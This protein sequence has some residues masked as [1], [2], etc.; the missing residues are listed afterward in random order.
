MKEKRILNILGQVNEDYIEEAAPKQK[1]KERP[2]WIRTGAM[3]ACLCLVLIGVL[4]FNQSSPQSFGLT[5]YAADGTSYEIG[6]VPTAISNDIAVNS[7]FYARVE[8]GDGYGSESFLFR[9]ICENNNVTSITYTIDNEITAQNSFEMVRNKAWFAIQEL[10][11]EAT[12]NV[13]PVYATRQLA[14]GTYTHSYIGNSFTVNYDEQSSSEVF[15]EYRIENNNGEWSADEICIDVN[16]EL[17]DGTIMQKKLLLCP[18]YEGMTRKTQISVMQPNE[19]AELSGD[20]TLGTAF[21]SESVVNINSAVTS[22]EYTFTLLSVVDGEYIT[23]FPR[24]GE[25]VQPERTYAILAIQKADGT[26]MSN[27]QNIE[28]GNTSFMV[29]PFVKGLAPWE[30][31]IVSMNGN[32]FETVVDGIMYRLIACDSVAAFADR[33]LYVG[34]CTSKFINNTTFLYDEVTGEISV[35]PD[36]DGVSAVFDLPLDEGLAD[37]ELAEQILKHIYY[38]QGTGD[39]DNDSTNENAA[40]DRI[41]KFKELS[42][43]IDWDKAMPIDST[44][45]SL[46]IGG[47]GEIS[48]NWEIGNDWSG[49]FSMSVN[50]YFE[51]GRTTHHCIMA[52]DDAEGNLFVYA[53]RLAK[54]DEDTVTAV[55]VVPE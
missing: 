5:A 27:P 40:T 19:I 26:P 14:E 45:K 22:G 37:P 20:K 35:N 31:N 51:N 2:K 3:V 47:D 7:R 23:D 46:D 6:E 48:Y 17:K 12:T 53:V 8:D 54:I 44:R 33:G 18:T 15:L 28:H 50:S 39:S 36:Y 13:F 52:R 32:Y 9:I 38:L 25:K 1:S 42:D 11:E 24:Y 34:V 41:S 30:V 21:D 55:V 29:S 16:I 43:G 10:T 49:S 4:Q